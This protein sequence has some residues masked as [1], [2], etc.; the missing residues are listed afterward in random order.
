MRSRDQR[1]QFGHGPA[2]AVRVGRTGHLTHVRQPGDRGQRGAAVG[3]AVELDLLGRVGERCR[4][5]QGLQG[6]RFARTA[7]AQDQHVG[8][9]ARGVDRPR[10][11]VVLERTVDDPDREDQI[12]GR[13]VILLPRVTE[14]PVDQL[15]DGNGPVQRRLPQPVRLEVDLAQLIDDHRADLRNPDALDV[16]VLARRAVGVERLAVGEGGRGEFRSAHADLERGEGVGKQL[17]ANVID[18]VHQRRRFVAVIGEPAREV[19]PPQELGLEPDDVLQ[20]AAEVSQTRLRR[21]VHRVRHAGRLRR[22]GGTRFQHQPVTHVL[23]ELFGA[24]FDGLRRHHQVDPV[25]AALPADRVEHVDRRRHDAE[26]FVELVDDH[27]EHRQRRHVLA[28]G[29]HPEPDRVVL[30][31]VVDTG[32]VANR[33]A[34]GDLAPQRVQ[35][36]LHQRLVFF[37]VGDDPRH[38]RDPGERLDRRPT[39]EVGQHELQLLRRVAE[40]QRFDHGPHQGR[41]TR[42]RRSGHDAVRTVTALVQR[43]H[44]QEQQLAVVGTNTE[45]RPQPRPAH[46]VGAGCPTTTRSRC[47]PDRQ[48]RSRP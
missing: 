20:A 2:H 26:P 22:T 14:E 23:H 19:V 36:A 15:V 9:R 30:L 42:T 37:Q 7:G 10:R 43:L 11:L 44:V 34:A 8:A 4:A 32:A 18:G 28:A 35:E 45:R 1:Q 13:T 31:G 33:L 48:F 16:L 46:R 47:G 27:H 40:H 3:Q 39:L 12:P 38:V 24:A 6:R 21:Q 29:L 17:R 5:D 25:G 41:F